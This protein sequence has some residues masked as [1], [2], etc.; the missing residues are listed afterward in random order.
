MSI[1]PVGRPSAADFAATIVKKFDTNGDGGVDKN[2][3]IAGLAAKGVSAEEAGK[4]F[5]KID[6]NHVG[7]ITQSDIETAI[8]ANAPKG[9]P[10]AG[11]HEGGHHEGG[12]AGGAAPAGGTQTKTYDPRDTNQDGTVSAQEQLLYQLSQTANSASVTSTAPDSASVG[13]NIDVKA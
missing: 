2:E 10:Q 3:F 1:S 5:D 11:K 13:T 7:K 8:K 4:R 9:A 12:K 6:I